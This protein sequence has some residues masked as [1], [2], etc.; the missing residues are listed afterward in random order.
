M[1]REQEHNTETKLTPKQERFCEEY[2]I[3]LNATQAAIRAGYSQKT[4]NEQ[5]SRLLANVNIQSYISELKNKASEIIEI[6]HQYVLNTLKQWLEYDIT[7][8]IELEPAQIKQLPIEIKRLITS[9]K[10][11]R[12]ELGEDVVKTT[13]E[14]K[15]VSKEKAIEMVNRHIGFYEKDNEQSKALIIQQIT[16]MEIK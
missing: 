13:I 12:I 8:T 9:Y 16:G 14:L 3:D 7:E 11:T 4:A 5:S 6:S 2:V 10:I 1:K 15:F